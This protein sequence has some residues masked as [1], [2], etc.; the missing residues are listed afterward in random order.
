[1]SK[2]EKKEENG[3]SAADKVGAEKAGAT[4]MFAAASTAQQSHGA[5]AVWPQALVK[6]RSRP[7][8]IA[9]RA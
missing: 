3:E 1:M 7:C 8:I 9:P 6:P 5:E 2:E 4:Q